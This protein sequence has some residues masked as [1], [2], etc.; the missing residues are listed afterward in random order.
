MPS[1]SYRPIWIYQRLIMIMII[2]III[3][4]IIIG[5]TNK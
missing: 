2:I 3:I 5:G 1:Y 4:I